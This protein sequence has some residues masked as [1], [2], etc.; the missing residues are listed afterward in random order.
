MIELYILFVSFH[1]NEETPIE[2]HHCLFY[3]E[4]NFRKCQI[5]L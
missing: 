4:G 1:L 3:F 2:T 5:I